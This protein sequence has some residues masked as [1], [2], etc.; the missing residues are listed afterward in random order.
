MPSA[1][2]IGRPGIAL[3]AA[4]RVIAAAKA[5]AKRN[6]R[7][8]SSAVLDAAGELVGFDRHDAA[9]GIKSLRG[10]RRA[11]T[12]ARATRRPRTP[13]RRGRRHHDRRL[14]TPAYP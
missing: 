1:I 4:R 10:H 2:A 11:R 7:A 14:T 13:F 12:A 8:I 9:I 5:K 6:G 3:A